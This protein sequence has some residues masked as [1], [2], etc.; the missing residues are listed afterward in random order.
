MSCFNLPKCYPVFGLDVSPVSLT[1]LFPC[2]QFCRYT[3]SCLK[4][5]YWLFNGAESNE[6]SLAPVSDFFPCHIACFTRI[7]AY[8]VGVAQRRVMQRPLSRGRRLKWWKSGS[9]ERGV[10]ERAS[11][12]E[13]PTTGHQLA[14]FIPQIVC[15]EVPS[16][17]I[18][19]P[20]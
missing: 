15:L 2:K 1:I 12:E 13:E 11:F 6:W 16:E 10:H 9:E 7:W 4:M 8:P 3:H 17:F 14:D 19:Y 18:M 20:V 5:Q